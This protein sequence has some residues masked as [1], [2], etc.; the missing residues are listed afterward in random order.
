MKKL[1]CILMVLC[2][3]LTG[4]FDGPDTT[5][6][7]TTEPETTPPETTA[8]PV[9]YENSTVILY[10]ANVRGDLEVFTQIAAVRD[11]Y[12]ALGSRVILV[13][14][15]NHLQGTVGANADMGLTVYNQMQE[16]GY[17]VLGMGVYELAY[18]EAE[19]GY[20]AHGDLTKF[21]TQAELY[22]GVAA[23][24]YQQNAS[25]AKEPVYAIREGKAATMFQVICSNLAI[26]EDAT[27]YYDFDPSA[28][29]GSVLKIGFVSYLPEDAADHLADGYL[30]GYTYQAVTAPECKVLV[31]LGGGEGDIVIEVPTDGEMTVGAYVIDNTTARITEER[32]V[33]SGSV[34]EELPPDCVTRLAD[35]YPGSRLEA[36]NSQTEL[37]TLVADALKWYAENSL[38]GIEYPLI[39]LFN[40]GNIRGFLYN[41]EVT[42]HDIRNALH[43][44]T[45]GMGVVYLTGQQLLEVL[46]AATQRENSAGWA[47]LSGLD[48]RVDTQK[49]YDF[50]AAYGLYYKAASINRVS[51]TTADFDPE[52]TYALAADMLLLMG[53]DT[54][55]LLKEL[56]VVARGEEGL[57]VCDIVALYLANR[58][59]Q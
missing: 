44:S 8:P 41:G 11:V 25:W 13:D 19:V 33:L 48:Y 47:Q 54:Y 5:G 28:V 9:D 16:A 26:G 24:R 36:C 4:C 39:G 43:G 46:E 57:D 15:G 34:S 45:Q 7:P 20:A 17:D 35:T 2:V 3:L 37:G 32:I 30:D 40:G 6:R 59:D 27:G 38:E 55:Y 1:Y 29:F 21:Y 42:E 49:A 23:I 56:E 14:A 12:E 18:G 31:S 50:G 53:E 58:N 52:A 22:R 51:V 10:T